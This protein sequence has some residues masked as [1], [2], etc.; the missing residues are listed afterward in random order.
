MAAVF[1]SCSKPR[2]APNIYLS[3]C[4]QEMPISTQLVPIVTRT[5]FFPSLMILRLFSRYW[6]GLLPEVVQWPLT[7]DRWS[8]D[9]TP[10]DL[11]LG[12]LFAG[13]I[14]SF[15]YTSHP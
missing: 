1:A 15:A 7:D 4:F 6:I 9:R 13:K 12:E 14:S 2:I 3:Y 11:K 5:R 10:S 8:T